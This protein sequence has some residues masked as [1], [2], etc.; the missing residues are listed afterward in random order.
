MI[1]IDTYAAGQEVVI[2]CERACELNGK[3]YRKGDQITIVLKR[4]WD[5]SERCGEGGPWGW[6]GYT[7]RYI[8]SL[9]EIKR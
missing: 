3:R 7:S 5:T 6:G 4:D 9:G 1:D 2:D 8:A